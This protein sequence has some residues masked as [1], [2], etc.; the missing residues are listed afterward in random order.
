MKPFAWKTLFTDFPD[1]YGGD[2]FDFSIRDGWK[3]LVYDLSKEIAGTGAKCVQCKQKFGGLRYYYIFQGDKQDEV[4]VEDAVKKAEGLSWKTCE[5][6]G[7]P[8]EQV[9]RDGWVNTF[10]NSCADR[11][12]RNPCR[13]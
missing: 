6:C 11:E 2:C 5:D 4:R 1:L 8:G 9:T 12:R 3:Q 13:L 10:C 7:Q